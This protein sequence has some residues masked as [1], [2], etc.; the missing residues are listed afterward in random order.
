[1]YKEG[2]CKSRICSSLN[3]DIRTL[4]KILKLRE[5]NKEYIYE[6]KRE[7][8]YIENVKKK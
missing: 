6:S 8:I 5:T 2:I 7:M 4:N 3:L 1:M